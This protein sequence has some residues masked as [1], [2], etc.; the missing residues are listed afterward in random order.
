MRSYYN[1][2]L[3]ILSNILGN[4]NIGGDVCLWVITKH[5][6]LQ[7]GVYFSYLAD[8]LFCIHLDELGYYLQ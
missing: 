6:T 7:A 5:N 2:D 1:R 8:T 4:R 3:C